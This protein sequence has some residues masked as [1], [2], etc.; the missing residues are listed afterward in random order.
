VLHWAHIR[1]VKEVP[2]EIPGPH[3]PPCNIAGDVI[4]A[5]A[6]EIATLTVDPS[7]GRALTPPTGSR[8]GGAGAQ[9]R[10][11]GAALQVPPRDVGSAVAVEVPYFHIDPGG[12]RAPSAPRLIRK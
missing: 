7:G 6:I 11:P 1:V 5:V 10:P 2:V 8:E 3:E 12:R 9:G 4:H